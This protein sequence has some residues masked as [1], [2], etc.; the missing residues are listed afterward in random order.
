MPKK[1]ENATKLLVVDDG[2]DIREYLKLYFE[3]RNF[4]VFTAESAEDALPI[5]KEQNPDIMFLDVNLPKMSGIELV[6]LIREFNNTIKVIM[7]SGNYFDFQKEPQLKTLDIFE[8]LHKP[9]GFAEL[10]LILKK[11]ISKNK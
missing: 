3:R 5:I 8:F 9:V 2:V 6:K 7:V 10:E 11:A 1:R 4:I